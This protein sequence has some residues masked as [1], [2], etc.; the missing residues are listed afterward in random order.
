MPDFFFYPPSGSGRAKYKQRPEGGYNVYIRVT[1][2]VLEFILG[3]EVDG[4][5]VFKESLF[6]RKGF[7]E[8]VENVFAKL[9]AQESG[10]PGASGQH[11]EPSHESNGRVKDGNFGL[12]HR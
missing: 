6:L 9:E 5:F 4:V 7:I 12:T 2:F 1:D 3:G 8:L 11:R 10:K